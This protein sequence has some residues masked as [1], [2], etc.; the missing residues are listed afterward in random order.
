MSTKPTLSILIPVYN[1]GQAIHLVIE[2]LAKTLLELTSVKSDILVVDDGSSDE[3]VEQILSVKS[4]I[5]VQLMRLSRNFGKEAAISAGLSLVQSDA[6]IIMD[7]DGQHPPELIK[8]FVQYWQQG[9]DVVYGK[10]ISR[11]TEHWLKRKLT[12]AYYRYVS[13]HTKFIEANAGDFRLISA[14]V[15]AGLNQLTEKSRF[16]KGLYNW[17]GYKRMAIH[18]SPRERIAN[19]SKF[20]IFSL[21]RFGVVGIT[22]FTTV[23]LRM[24][25]QFGFIIAALSLLYGS[26]LIVSTLIFGFDVPGWTTIVVS[27]MLIGG[28]QLISIGVLGEYIGQIFIETKN[29][30]LFLI[31]EIVQ[32]NAVEHS[33]SSEWNVV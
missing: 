32:V 23:P 11:A 30:P 10:R 14:R 15:V 31:D 17:V 21:I 20:N 2:E 8:L 26:Y 1:E 6:V 13:K 4:E 29:R 24:I 16:M 9:Y 19:D 7:G 3:T 18:F 12:Q 5:P 27:I 25:I 22:S 28:I 33:K